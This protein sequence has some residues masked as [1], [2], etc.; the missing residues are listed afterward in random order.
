MNKVTIIA[1]HEYIF[2]RH[3]RLIERT[4]AIKVLP[5][6]KFDTHG[7]FLICSHIN[8]PRSKDYLRV[9]IAHGTSNKWQKPHWCGDGDDVYDYYFTS[10][11]KLKWSF[12]KFGH[13]LK[14]KEVKIGLMVTDDFLQGEFDAGRARRILNIRDSRPILLFAPTMATDTFNNCAML[15][16]PLISDYHI[17]VKPH[18]Q[19]RLIPGARKKLSWAKVYTDDINEILFAADVLV[20]D[21]SS[22]AYDFAVTGR[23]IVLAEVLKTKRFSDPEQYNLKKH[24]AVWTFQ[25]GEN[26]K[27]KIKEAEDRIE[28]VKKLVKDSFYFNDGHAVDRACKWIEERRFE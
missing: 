6:T 11:P 27:D 1:D 24:T 8:V 21:M 4:N 19:E 18:P 10:G 20:S 12:E 7:V 22:V 25:V 15:L 26:I 17:V 5:G 9:Y 3:K 14:N 28:E 23:P 2:T 16:K 13:N